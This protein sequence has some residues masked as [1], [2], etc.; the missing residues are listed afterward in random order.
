AWLRARPIATSSTRCRQATL[1]RR[2]TTTRTLSNSFN[3][4]RGHTTDEHGRTLGWRKREW[5]AL[6]KAAPRTSRARSVRLQ[7]AVHGL[8]ERAA[9]LRAGGRTGDGAHPQAVILRVA[10]RVAGDD[11]VVARFQRLA[12]HSLPVQL[13]ARA[14]LHGVTHRVALR[15]LAFDM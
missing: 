6:K 8:V 13:Q 9:S 14:P 12:R 5:T 7:P 3:T 2:D 15:V 4:P 10:A 1:R 11:Y